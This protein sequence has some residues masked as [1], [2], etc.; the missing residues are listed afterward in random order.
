MFLTA[1]GLGFLCLTAFFCLLAFLNILHHGFF[2]VVE[3]NIVVVFVE[4]G[5]CSFALA[6]GVFLFV[7]FLRKVYVNQNVEG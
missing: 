6:Y 5:Y 3:P 4:I 2:F 7:N 1:L